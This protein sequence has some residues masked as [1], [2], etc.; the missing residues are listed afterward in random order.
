MNITELIVQNIGT[1]VVFV[2]VIWAFSVGAKR[3]FPYYSSHASRRKI[4]Q[5]DRVDFFPIV[6]KRH[7]RWAKYNKRKWGKTLLCVGD[8]DIP[9]KKFKHMGMIPRK[10]IY[11]VQIKIGFPSHREWGII[12]A[13]II[14]DVNTRH[15]RLDCRGFEPHGDFIVPIW[16]SRIDGTKYTPIIEDYIDSMLQR[17][18][19]VLVSEQTANSIVEA[20]QT[21]YM[22]PQRFSTSP[23]EEDYIVEEGED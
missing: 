18:T 4:V 21:R 14:R 6:K 19:G 10:D 2:L 13:G 20:P 15:I 17:H 8:G 11:E 3:F 5:D 23:L 7:E 16:S 22:P 12:P 9:K 1:I